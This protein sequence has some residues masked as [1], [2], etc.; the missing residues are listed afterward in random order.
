[1]TRRF[2]LDENAVILAQKGENDRGERDATCLELLVAII[3][4][5]HTLV[6]D[7]ALWAKYQRQLNSLGVPSPQLGFRI[8]PILANAFR[9]VGKMDFR[10]EASPF[11]EES[12][13]PSGSRD[14]TP[15]VRLAVETEAPLVTT[16]TALMDDLNACGVMEKYSLQLLLPDEALK[17]VQ[18]EGP[19]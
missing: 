13:I 6:L 10:P 19:P 4:I 18:S 8:L 2:I 14:D 12:D 1:M 7:A 15:V 11:P 5:C 16:D 3:R 17:Q 9:T